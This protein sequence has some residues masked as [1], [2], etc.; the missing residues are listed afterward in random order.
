MNLRWHHEGKSP[1]SNSSRSNPAALTAR[2]EIPFLQVCQLS[3]LS[4][5]S[6][7]RARVER[8]TRH[9][10]AHSASPPRSKSARMRSI[11]LETPE[12]FGASNSIEL[13][14]EQR[15]VEGRGVNQQPLQDVVPPGQVCPLHAARS[16][17]V[18]E[19]PFDPFRARTRQPVSVLAPYT[20]PVSVNQV[21]LGLPD[22]RAHP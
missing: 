21:A 18:R 1:K 19:T 10:S 9:I 5:R 12:A 4:F 8:L 16:A 15:D 17:H 13:A 20:L 2:A 14:P 7:Q 11:A 3:N 6:T 22:D